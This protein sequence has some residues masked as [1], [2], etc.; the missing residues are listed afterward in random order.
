MPRH[1]AIDSH[2][3]IYD[4]DCAFCTLWVNRLRDWLPVFPDARTSQSI[5]LDSFALTKDDV[6][7]YAWYITPSHQYAGHL[8]TSALLRA[9]PRF[10]LRLLGRLLATWP[11][12]WIAAGVYAFIARFRHKLPG[13]TPAC[14]PATPLR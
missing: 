4:G 14:D 10:A 2:V 1:S 9:Q 13:G 6:E 8:A 3:L 12:S 11:I 7:K 5:T